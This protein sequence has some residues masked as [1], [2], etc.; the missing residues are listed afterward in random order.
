MNNSVVFGEMGGGVQDESKFTKV[1]ETKMKKNVFPINFYEIK[2]YKLSNL[3]PTH[4]S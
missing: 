1:E 2:S 4:V 3:L